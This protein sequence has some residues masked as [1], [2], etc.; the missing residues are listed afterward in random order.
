IS[1]VDRGCRRSLWRR[2]PAAADLRRR[3]NHLGH[4]GR[5][6]RGRTAF[7]RRMMHA[8]AGKDKVDVLLV[9]GH[10]LLVRNF[11]V[12]GFLRELILRGATV[13]VVAP[14]D[15]LPMIRHL[16][17]ELKLLFPLSRFRP[18][19]GRFRTLRW[20]RLGS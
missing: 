13:A 19:K 20:L 5:L 4:G 18:S 17:P 3:F 10:V 14:D 2:L 1:P 15:T 12:E 9:L 7:V 8:T 11:V 6:D 16:V